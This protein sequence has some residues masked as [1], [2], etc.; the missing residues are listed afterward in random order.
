VTAYDRIALGE[1]RELGAYTFTADEIKRFARAYDPQSFHIDEEAAKASIFRG[2]CASGWH[3][4]SVMMRLLVDYS[5][6]EEA[7]AA[8]RG[9][10]PLRRGLSPGFDSLKWLK[11]VYAGDTITFVGQ[12]VG[13]RK[14]ASRPDW[15]IVSMETTGTNQKGEPAFTITTHVFVRSQDD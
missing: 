9:E 10:V 5:T 8:S 12:V 15:G 2:L 6:R 11:P 4:A 7:S 1:I 13:K 14:S 3:T